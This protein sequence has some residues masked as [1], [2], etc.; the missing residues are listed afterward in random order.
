[1]PQ[2]SGS[3]DPR[4]VITPDAFEVAPQLLGL[5]LA[6]PLR[7]GAATLVDLILIG[8]ITLVTR[9]I[10]AI[11]GVLVAMVFV[12][13]AWKTPMT[14][15]L[16]AAL[17][18]AFRFSVG[19]LGLVILGISFLAFFLIRSGSDLELPVVDATVGDQ[20]VSMPVSDLLSGLQG[21]IR[22]AQASS[23]AEAESA[24]TEMARAALASGMSTDDVEDLLRE[25]VPE[26]APW[27]DEADQIIARSLRAAEAPA[28]PLEADAPG[29][30]QAQ[31]VLDTLSAEGALVAYARMIESPDSASG[32][33]P[34]RLRDRAL[35]AVAAD[36]M[37]DLETQLRQVTRES[38]RNERTIQDL[39]TRVDELEQGSGLVRLVRD[40]IDQLGLAFGWGSIYFAVLLPWWKGQTPGKKLFGV[41]V[42]RLD[43]EPISWWFAFERAGGYAAGFATGLLGFAQVY[44][45]PNRQGI[46]DKIAGTVVV[47]DGAPRVPTAGA[48]PSFDAG[49]SRGDASTRTQR[50]EE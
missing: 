45:D 36:T 34:E 23:A 17:A 42:L 22:L 27:A 7:R 26:D 49:S 30:R 3:A 38:E 46:H 37:L 28:A 18:W 4:A 5:P 10:G 20:P 6:R 33:D 9:D 21:G 29:D 44:W 50:M 16:P 1:M 13:M 25:F 11:V 41:R 47:V 32:I 31:E 43:G 40:V 24:A 19:C 12:R 35:L 39:Q 2:V 48:D 8:L 14:R 15:D